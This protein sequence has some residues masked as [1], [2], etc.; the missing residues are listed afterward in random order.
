MFKL[1][2]KQAR[3]IFAQRPGRALDTQ[4]Q[5]TFQTLNSESPTI[6]GQ[7]YNIAS[8]TVRNVWN[9]KAWVLAT[10]P[11]WTPEEIAASEVCNEDAEVADN[12]AVIPA[13][14]RK[15]G[16]PCGAKNAFPRIKRRFGSASD[17]DS[18][19]SRD[20]S[21]GTTASSGNGTSCNALASSHTR[22]LSS[23]ATDAR[24]TAATSAT[25]LAWNKTAFEEVERSKSEAQ[26]I[27]SAAA[28][29]EW[30]RTMWKTLGSQ[31]A[32][33]PLVP[34]KAQAAGEGPLAL[35]IAQENTLRNES[36]SLQT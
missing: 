22:E 14:M 27:Q 19:L 7:R 36:T 8:R 32:A 3:E 24:L 29:D 2:E 12:A 18:V 25:A 10:R 30:L 26:L 28:I 5:Y 31:H 21:D 33:A 4:G 15:R 17:C 6:V 16:R 1:T 11:D 34:Q 23:N 20:G 13:V 35:R 9:R